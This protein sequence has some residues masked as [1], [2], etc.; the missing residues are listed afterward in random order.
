MS[1]E[2]HRETDPRETE[3]TEEGAKLVPEG[4]TDA[5][6]FMPAGEAVEDEEEDEK[7]DEQEDD[8]SD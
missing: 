3:E 7:E 5:R 4:N 2:L 6:L 8:E 1:E